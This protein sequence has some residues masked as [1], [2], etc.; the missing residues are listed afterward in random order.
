MLAKWS[1]NLLEDVAVQ[2]NTTPHRIWVW[3]TLLLVMVPGLVVATF[4][5]RESKER[6]GFGEW[7]AHMLNLMQRLANIIADISPF[8]LRP[9]LFLS[10][11]TV[12][13]IAYTQLVEWKQ[14]AAP[15]LG[16]V[17]LCATP[18]LLTL[19]VALLTERRLARRDVLLSIPDA[20][21]D[22]VDAVTWK[23]RK[24]RALLM[25]RFENELMRAS[26]Q[27][28]SR[29]SAMFGFLASGVLLTC[30]VIALRFVGKHMSDDYRHVHY[31]IPMATGTAALV[32][33]TVHF[34]KVL[35]RSASNDATAR[36]MAWATRA[37]LMV[38]LA[39]VFLAATIMST[40]SHA[41]TSAPLPQ[42]TKSALVIGIAAGLLGDRALQ[43]VTD[44]AAR[45]FGLEN[46]K[47]TN[48]ADLAAIDGLTEEDIAR[49]AE[50]RIDSLH[51]LAFV[52]TPRLFFNT[53]YSLQ[54]I[55]EWQ[56]QALLIAHFGRTKAIL[57]RDQHGVRGVL[58]ARRLAEQ[59]EAS[60]GTQQPVGGAP[61]SGQQ[62]RTPPGGQQNGDDGAKLE[63]VA[64]AFG[65]QDSAHAAKSLR[66]LC[67]D[68][69][70]QRLEVFWRA[71]P[72]WDQD[73]PSR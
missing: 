42:D 54:R 11:A 40:S 16:V 47:P 5:Y 62:G 23:A 8:M 64:I 4:A 73:G 63:A 51:A 52:P 38:S 15:R 69:V 21:A 3:L 50:E 17:V 33:F 58:A 68:E 31:L 1:P 49:L 14:P 71:M 7:L 56:D 45:M 55:C 70:F 53:I 32:S 9:V 2:L 20:P 72:Y 36:M 19:C 37:L 25:W 22:G 26:V 29:H 43:A 46:I 24:D 6:G 13:Y 35:F 66:A 59:F 65:F 61:P 30:A 27:R 10:L 48:F 57:L 34:G 67:D 18:N 12:L 44:Q 28:L 41:Q 39:T 60:R